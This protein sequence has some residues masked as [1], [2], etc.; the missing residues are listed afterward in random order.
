MMTKRLISALFLMAVA[1]TSL[2][3]QGTTRDRQRD[4]RDRQQ[5]NASDDWCRSER[6]GNDRETYC[7]V[8]PATVTAAG[9]LSVDA[10]P[11]GG[12]EVEGSPRNDVQISAKVTASAETMQRA[13][14]I[15]DSVRINAN[16][17]NVSADGPTG[18]G[19]REGWS[20]SYRLSV[21]VI[22]SLALRTTNGGISIRDVD[23]EIEFKTVNGGVRLSN[24]AGDVKGRTSN[25]GVDVDLDGPSWKGGG[26]DVETSNG[27]VHLRIPE[28]Y[29]AHLE[30]GTVNGGFNIDFPI[31]VRGRIDREISADLGAG[32][33]PIR[34]RTHNGGVKVS[35]K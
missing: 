26:L 1:A 24:L 13:R 27:G 30:T 5:F 16:A 12:I 35:K 14:Q 3:A 10:Q 21:P 29:S 28:Q 31:T 34:V 33:A 19:R 18:L 23:G 32:G 20:V 9:T 25:G 6:W 17:S 4:T 22:S 15:A 8:R 2:S 7:E 11:N